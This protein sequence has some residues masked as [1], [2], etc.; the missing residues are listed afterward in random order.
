[1]AYRL[2][3]LDPLCIKYED[4][5]YFDVTSHLEAVIVYNAKHYSSKSNDPPQRP[6]PKPYPTKAYDTDFLITDNPP[7]FCSRFDI[8]PTSGNIARD[9][10]E[11]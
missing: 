8:H 10:V 3:P 11:R 7:P 1:M 6:P 2:D 5:E 4:F 9:V